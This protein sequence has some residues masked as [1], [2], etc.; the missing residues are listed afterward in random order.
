MCP[1]EALTDG[2][3][4]PELA[5]DPHRRYNPL[6][7]EWVLVSAG[8]VARPWQGAREPEVV[9]E[10]PRYVS[11]CYLCPGN[12]RAN[13]DRNP[14]YD[15]TF[16]FDNDFAALRADT[17]EAV[18]EHGLLRAEGE[19]GTCRVVCFSPRHDLTL[20]AMSDAAIGRVVDVWADQTRDLGARHRWVQVFENRG[21]AMGASNPH[22]HGQIWA[23][24]ALPVEARREAATQAAHLDATG[25]RLLLAYAEQE[26]GGPR[27]VVETERW[28][29]VVPFWAAWPFETLVLPREPAAR[30]PDLAPPA[31]VDLASALGVLLRRYD[32]LFGEPFP[33]SMGWHQAPTTPGHAEADGWQLHAHF[34]PPLLRAGVRK[35]MVGYELLAETQRDVTAEEAAERLREVPVGPPPDPSAD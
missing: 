6:L 3:L 15:A 33:Y 7:D 28:L 26:A 16:V 24:S 20:G 21:A 34:Y 32:G 30:L 14:A 9:H 17:S 5:R 22:P 18:L 31:R 2:L 8:R 25:Q 4:P 10:R 35:F 13:G 29:V 1:E 23:G 19:R 11:D 27:V 12:V